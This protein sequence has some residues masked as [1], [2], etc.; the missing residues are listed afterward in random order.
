MQRSRKVRIP[1]YRLHKPSGQA[2][3][4]IRGKDCY[5]GQ[6]GSGPSRAE[7]DRLI[8][9][10]LANQSTG[11]A[12][13]KDP[14]DLT[15]AELCS[16][17]VE[18]AERYYRKRDQPTSEIHTI[19]KT[20]KTLRSLY[21][22]VPATDYGPLALKTCRQQW[23][24][25]GI[26]RGGVNRLARTVRSIFRW[27]AE[28]ELVPVAAWQ[29]L[30]AVSG[31][32]RGR[33][34]APDPEPVRPVAEDVLAKTLE[35]A[36]P[37]LRAMI[38]T[39]LKTGMRPGELVQLRGAELDTSGPIWVYKPLSHKLE[40]QGR[41]RIV[42]IGPDAQEVLKP[43]LRDDPAQFIF[44]ARQLREYDLRDRPTPRPRTAWEKRNRKRRVLRDHYTSN[45]Y[46]QAVRRGVRPGQGRLVVTGPTPPQCRDPDSGPLR[47]RSRTNRIG[48]LEHRH[49]ANLR[50]SRPRQSGQD[51]GGDRL[52]MGSKIPA[53]E[54][55][56]LKSVEPKDP[57]LE[58]ARDL[59]KQGRQAMAR[60]AERE[61][62]QD[63]LPMIESCDFGGAAP[64][65]VEGAERLSPNKQ[66]P[67]PPG[68]FR[69]ILWRISLDVIRYW[70]RN[71]I[72]FPIRD[73]GGVVH[74]KQCCLILA[75]EIAEYLNCSCIYSF[76][77]VS[78]A[79]LLRFEKDPDLTQE[80]SFR[81]EL[82]SSAA[83]A[84][85]RRLRSELVKLIRGIAPGQAEWEERFDE[86]LLIIPEHARVALL[87]AVRKL[88]HE[89]RPLKGPEILG[90]SCEPKKLNALSACLQGEGNQQQKGYWVLSPVLAG[91]EDR[92]VRIT[93]SRGDSQYPAICSDHSHADRNLARSA[94]ESLP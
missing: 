4:T 88:E 74:Y 87:E 36:H 18:H 17:Y 24:E 78:C 3:V 65:L 56:S 11:H 82:L 43:W 83:Y 49:D 89:D 46:L 44:G 14:A 29:A 19:R 38:S 71:S 48:P 28:N 85:V 31:S 10:Y 7:Y 13:R 64:K 84:T 57:R 45:G 93:Y 72:P 16:K 26:T 79:S 23:I 5:L 67:K 61:E 80:Q 86:Y 39:Q 8:A 22:H 21:A 9:E 94:W 47:G 91:I 92:A 40:H 20:V 75:S 12:T 42:L 90:A 25:E 41:E 1:S 50:R 52:N 60:V 27:A 34:V 37:M 76:E 66:G 58:W 30:T 81:L 59:V 6:Y 70:E 68:D 62:G 63:D 15:I 73:P 69:L 54:P 55:A 77:H 51:H 2:V 35:V 53:D 32:R 33:T